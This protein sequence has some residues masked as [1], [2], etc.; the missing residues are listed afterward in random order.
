MSRVLHTHLLPELF[1]PDELTGGVAVV[2]DILRA[3]TTMTTALAHGARCIL[4][5]LHVEE[6]L[7]EKQHFPA[8]SV[9]LGGER[10]GVLIP[11]F[12]LGNSPSDYSAERV[13]QKTVL[14]TTSNGTKALARCASAEEV[15]IGCFLNLSAV[16]NWLA[17]E[18]RP[19]HL[20]CAGTNGQITLE[21][22]L[23]AGVLAQHLQATAQETQTNDSTR[24]CLNLAER[25]GT[26][27]SQILAGLQ[28]SQGGRNLTALQLAD[29]LLTCAQLDSIS[30]VPVWNKQTAQIDIGSKKSS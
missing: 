19:I 9:L 21:D 8:D 4:P 18:T 3:S 17:E 28:H 10:G 2:I 22:C 6:A 23:F 11:G 16:T 29:D 27:S 7:A 5:R 26:D 25:W 1:S 15:L 20:V 30:I 14:F 24:I 12:D 13:S